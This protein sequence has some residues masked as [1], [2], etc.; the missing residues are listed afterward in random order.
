LFT[1]ALLGPTAAPSY[2]FFGS[3]PLRIMSELSYGLYLWHML[4]LIHAADWLGGKDVARFWPTLYIA[5]VLSMAASL[6]TYLTVERPTA[7]LRNLGLTLPGSHGTRPRTA[8]TAR[9]T[10]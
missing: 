6:V 1:P 9:H 3:R 10:A 2:R 7:R 5:L 4:F 8:T